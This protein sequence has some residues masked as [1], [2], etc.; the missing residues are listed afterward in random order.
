MKR[1]IKKTAS[2]KH[3]F[4][5]DDW[6]IFSYDDEGNVY[7]VSTEMWPE[8]LDQPEGADKEPDAVEKYML[9]IAQKQWYRIHWRQDNEIKTVWD[10]WPENELAQKFQ[11]YNLPFNPTKD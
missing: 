7:F 5:C 4:M 8:W 3:Y 11:Q 10:M 6:L 1:L 2:Q 9:P